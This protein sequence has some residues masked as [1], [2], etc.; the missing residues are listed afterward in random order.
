MT[1]Q[2]LGWVDVYLLS[3]SPCNPCYWMRGNLLLNNSI[4][5]LCCPLDEEGDGGK[6]V[7][8]LICSCPSSLFLLALIRLER[9]QGWSTDWALCHAGTNFPTDLNARLTMVCLIP[10]NMPPSYS[11]WRP[12]KAP[13]ISFK[14]HHYL[15]RYNCWI[16]SDCLFLVP[17]CAHYKDRIYF[18]QVSIECGQMWSA[19]KTSKLLRCRRNL[20]HV[21]SSPISKL[22][23]SLILPLTKEK[24]I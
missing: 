9:R 7:P 17:C 5:V 19:P 22:A 11:S 23:I 10:T 8:L 13:R 6:E 16:N 21:V 2:L 1:R 3:P 20:L 4:S 14:L 24:V 18:C 15:S 12:N